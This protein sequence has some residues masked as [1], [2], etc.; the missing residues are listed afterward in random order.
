[1]NS[2]SIGRLTSISQSGI[3]AEIYSKLGNYIN[4]ADGVRFVGEVGSYITIYDI[5]RI[6]VGE[7]TGVSE[8]PDISSRTAANWLAYAAP[9]L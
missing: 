6:I 5:G 7:I 2:Y 1:M 8:K 3:T 9:V 4:T